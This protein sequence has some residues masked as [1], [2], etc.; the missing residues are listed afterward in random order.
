MRDQSSLVTGKAEL[1]FA[2]ANSQEVVTR[3]KDAIS[4][5]AIPS[6]LNF[7]SLPSEVSPWPEQPSTK[8]INFSGSPLVQYHCPT[9]YAVVTKNDLM[10]FLSAIISYAA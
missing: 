3:V 8:Q 6:D 4:Q 10:I 1:V 5:F 9:A 7:R 2:D